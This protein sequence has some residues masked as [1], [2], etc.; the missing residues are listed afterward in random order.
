MSE[1]INSNWDAVKP[2]GEENNQEYLASIVKEINEINRKTGQPEVRLMSAEEARTGIREEELAKGREEALDRSRE[3]QLA[4]DKALDLENSKEMEQT[5]G[6]DVR[7]I[8]AEEAA[9][10]EE[11]TKKEREVVP[12]PRVIRQ[13]SEFDPEMEELTIAKEPRKEI[14]VIGQGTEPVDQELAKKVEEI[15]ALKKELEEVDQEIASIKN[16]EPEEAP[17]PLV[18][19][20]VD[21]SKS[22]ER[23]AK[24]LAEKELNKELKE[25]GLIKKIWKGRLFRQ[26]YIDLYTEEFLDGERTDKNGKTIAEAI[27][28]Q[29]QNLIDDFR[30]DAVEEMREIDHKRWAEEGFRGKNGEKLTPVDKETNAKIKSTIEDYAKFMLDVSEIRP[31]VVNDPDFIKE[32]DRKFN[33]YMDEMVEG[34]ANNYLDIAKTVAM[35]YMNIAKNAKSKV[36]QETA[37]ARVMAGFQAYDVKSE[38]AFTVAKK[39]NIT[40]ILDFIEKNKISVMDAA[41]FS[42]AVDDLT[43]D[44]SEEALVDNIKSSEELIGGEEGIKIMLDESPISV[45]SQKRWNEWWDGLSDEGREYVGKLVE[46]VN[47]YPDRYN[48]KW[49][50]GFRTWLIIKNASKILAA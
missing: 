42:E 4:T 34:D 14:D 31:D 39:A 48:L 36:E 2:G 23:L 38:K 21:W 16:K 5:R 10:R 33:R 28:E 20:N 18:A 49:G 27:E 17:E 45:E 41:D 9:K 24:N 11:A 35:R 43:L 25:A 6:L 40:K 8:M 44:T 50:N 47:R 19:M 15:M 22:E 13:V 29:K 26:T 12:A 37:M 30:N 46:Q 32:V 7:R 1:K 3:I